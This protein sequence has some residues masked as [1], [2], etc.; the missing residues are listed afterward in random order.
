[1]KQGGVPF[2]LNKKKLQAR[3][4]PMGAM[5]KREAT[6]IACHEDNC[7]C[8]DESTRDEHDPGPQCDADIAAHTISVNDV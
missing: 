6:A 1:M 7:K 8:R 3:Y 5:Q 4:A 2:S